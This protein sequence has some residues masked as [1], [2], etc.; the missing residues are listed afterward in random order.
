MDEM[1]VD[2]VVPPDPRFDGSGKKKQLKREYT[3]ETGFQE[4]PPT[5]LWPK[6]LVR[7]LADNQMVVHFSDWEM[8]KKYVPPIDYQKHTVFPFLW[9]NQNIQR[10]LQKPELIQGINNIIALTGLAMPVYTPLLFLM[11]NGI[12]AGRNPTT[13]TSFAPVT[14]STEVTTCYLQVATLLAGSTSE[15]VTQHGATVQKNYDANLRMLTQRLEAKFET[16]ADYLSYVQHLRELVEKDGPTALASLPDDEAIL[17][18]LTGYIVSHQF[19]W[20]HL[21]ELRILTLAD[22]KIDPKA[23]N[24]LF[25]SQAALPCAAESMLHYPVAQALEERL[26]AEQLSYLRL[27]AANYSLLPLIPAAFSTEQRVAGLS[28]HFL[29]TLFLIMHV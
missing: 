17:R 8:H 5:R 25:Y 19:N 4:E 10:E 16:D 20:L 22:A 26:L 7:E 2:G 28:A 27:R 1:V 12:R 13:V 18:R 6:H 24:R 14:L 11:L 9:G 21:L 15:H 29:R 23:L 3:F